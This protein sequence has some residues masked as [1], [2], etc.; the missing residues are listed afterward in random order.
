MGAGYSPYSSSMSQ[1]YASLVQSQFELLSE[2]TGADRCALYFRKEHPA[3]GQLE[4]GVVAV[5]PQ[6]NR[7]WLVDEAGTSIPSSLALELPGYLAAE[8]L[9][10]QYPFIATRKY[11]GTETGSAFEGDDAGLTAPLM[12]GGTVIG[13]LKAWKK[14]APWGE[15]DFD[16]TEKVAASLAIAAVLDQRQQWTAAVVQV[17]QLRRVLAETLHQAK[18]PLTALRTFSKLLLRRLPSDDSINKELAKD[19]LLQSDRLIDLLLPVDEVISV[20]EGVMNQ[21]ASQ[22]SSG[23]MLTGGVGYPS[24]ELA[25]ASPAG[26][27]DL[28][29]AGTSSFAVQRPPL[30][31]MFLSDVM[32][33]ALHAAEAVA[34][35]RN[36]TFHWNVDEDLPGVI[37]DERCL[38]EAL[39]NILDNA[40]KYVLAVRPTHKGSGRTHKPII[41]LRVRPSADDDWGESAGLVID[42]CDNGP[43]I[44]DEDLLKVFRRGFRGKNALDLEVEGT[45]LGLGIARDVM[46][47]MGGDL[48]I[49]NRRGGSG[50]CACL[51]LPRMR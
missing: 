16:V 35:A 45:G 28:P 49:V 3:T 14:Q 26:E 5:Y 19:I 37:G 13:M 4:F 25:R 27:P 40:L 34:A 18:N 10:P 41:M 17:D 21:H 30:T 31:V 24:F 50:T 46:H 20:L 48:M 39:S 22:S 8:A 32:Q 11:G 47:A 36:V 38:E 15:G 42:V 1:E 7:V 51:F 44:A 43:G 23:A 29:D 12:N 33:P 2:A 9:M 6:S